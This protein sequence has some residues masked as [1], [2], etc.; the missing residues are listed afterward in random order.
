VTRGKQG[1]VDHAREGLALRE[2]I[3]GGRAV[4][5]R[6]Q[7]SRDYAGPKQPERFFADEHG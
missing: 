3:E 7:G 1:S 5:G 2:C 4:T 6:K